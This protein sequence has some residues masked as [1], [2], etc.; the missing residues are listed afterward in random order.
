MASV[1]PETNLNLTNV[2]ASFSNGGTETSTPKEY[3]WDFE[4]NDFKLKDGK[5]QIVEGTEALKIW[6]WKALKT[7][8]STYPIYSDAYGHEFEKLIGKGLSKSLVESEAKRLT[9]EC[10][11]DNEHILSIKNFSVDKSDDALSITFTAVTDCGEVTI[12]V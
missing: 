9:L 7:S 6:I 3:A 8:R 4:K 5:F 10:L 1:L 2:V 12:D 11:K